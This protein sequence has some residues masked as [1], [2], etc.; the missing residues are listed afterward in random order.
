MSC[1]R[2]L[3]SSLAYTHL[4]SDWLMMRPR[5]PAPPLLPPYP[6]PVRSSAGTKWEIYRIQEFITTFDGPFQRLPND[7][8]SGS[9]A[10]LLVSTNRL[11]S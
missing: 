1:R 4:C 6:L 5:D 11:K 10:G 3:Q 2:M 9:S 7:A 8:V